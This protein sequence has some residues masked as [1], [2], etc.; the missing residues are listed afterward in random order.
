MS[1]RQLILAL[2]ES[3]R[4]ATLAGL[5]SWRS[6]GLL[7]PLAS[8]GVGSGRSYYWREPNILE[9]AQTA[10]DALARHGRVDVALIGLWLNGFAV[11]LPRLRRAWLHG[12]KLR[13]A[14]PVRS[15]VPAVKG[16]VA[17]LSQ[18]LQ[19]AALGAAGA[20]MPDDKSAA[21]L[22]LLE[23]AA[24]RLGLRKSPAAR[25]SLHLALVTAGA[26]AA[27]DLVQSA[28]DAM[29]IR[30][31]RSVQ[32]A[33]DFL[34]ES[35]GEGSRSAVAEMLGEPLFLYCLS[36]LCSGQEAVLDEAA[37]RIAAWRRRPVAA[38]APLH[39]RA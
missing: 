9:H 36:L 23:R 37:A 27:S 34:W 14:R 13:K 39:A 11:P 28:S 20:L 2:A 12:R 7:P 24:A 22:A 35:G 16:P 29:M 6:D 25:Q 30:A 8:S 31:Q 15:S 18:L 5:V 33:L 10:H 1:E 4:T 38:V 26:L 3:G 32:A 17:D 19:Q 21:A